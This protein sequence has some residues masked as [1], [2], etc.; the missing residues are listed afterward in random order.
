MPPERTTGPLPLSSNGEASLMD[1]F[2]AALPGVSPG[3]FDE[4][5]FR[6][7]AEI[8]YKEA[9]IILPEGKSMLV[10]A[11]LSP[12]VRNTNCATFASYVIR[13]REDVA[14]RRRAICALTT[15][16][17][18]FYQH[19][20]Q[21]EHFA[22]TVRPGYVQRLLNGGKVRL[23]SAGCGNGAEA[24]G[25]LMTLLGDDVPQGK[26]LAKS[27]LRLLAT[28]TSAATIE[29]AREA[30]YR[31]EDLS[32]LPEPLREAWTHPCGEQ[33]TIAREIQQIARLRTLNLL[34]EWPLQGQFDTIFCRNTLRQFDETTREQVV[35]RLA[36]QLNPG[37]W[38]Y[39]D[40][41]EAIPGAIGDVLEHAGPAVFQKAA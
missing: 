14:E 19:P 27:D 5:D 23:W 12:L 6:A 37:G 11:R 28:D 3:V 20:R 29:T 4:A 33:S 15:S 38:L 26:T 18:A 10:F 8:A 34:D 1:A 7:I 41:G 2:D 17:A 32:P 31:N 24:W 30:T 39:L 35:L 16:H 36:K 22:Q 21:F 13:I 9:G 25:L 40:D